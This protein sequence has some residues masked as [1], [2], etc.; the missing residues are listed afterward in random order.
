MKKFL[1]LALFLGAFAL[2]SAQTEIGFKYQDHVYQSGDTLNVTVLVT[3]HECHG[4]HFINQTDQDLQRIVFSMEPIEE[5][6]INIFALCTG[7]VCKPGLETDPVT[8]FANVPYDEFYIDMDIDANLPEP[9]CVYTLRVSNDNVNC[10]VVVRFKAVRSAAI[11]PIVANTSL[12]AFPNPAQT[13]VNIRYSVEQPSTLAI[14]D[15]QGRSVRQMQVTGNGSIMVNDLP[16]GL[17]AYGILGSNNMK[18]LI[19]K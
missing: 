4:I 2:L 12:T 17:Y 19:V 16:A 7:M 6:G 13:D 1:S 3:D 18:K 15:M 10:A 5:N 9:S 14:V 11:E 8:I